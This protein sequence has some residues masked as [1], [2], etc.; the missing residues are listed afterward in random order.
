MA[1]VDSLSSPASGATYNANADCHVFF[2]F[3]NENSNYV[4][5]NFRF[6]S[7]NSRVWVGCRADV[8]ANPLRL[9]YNDGSITT[10]ATVDDI[11]DD[12]VEVRV[13]IYA[14]GTNIKVDVDDVEKINETVAYNSTQTGG[15]VDHTLDTNDIEL[16]SWPYGEPSA[17][18]EV[19]QSP[20]GTLAVTG[21]R[22]VVLAASAWEIGA[23]IYTTVGGVD[24]NARLGAMSITGYDP[25]ITAPP[26][27]VA[28]SG[29]MSRVAMKTI[30]LLRR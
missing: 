11:F 4:V 27:N 13:D 17:G 24:V 8:G 14:N 9:R 5:V 12:D 25:V 10:V 30:V 23:Y 16:E 22:P 2:T 26:P 3:T 28:G 18:V 6:S 7:Q 21:Y 15:R 19:T 1:I 20:L 29:G